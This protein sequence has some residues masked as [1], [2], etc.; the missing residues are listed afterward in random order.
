MESYNLSHTTLC[1]LALGR[2][3]HLLTLPIQ[4]GDK[5]SID[6]SEILFRLGQLRQ[7]L[8]AQVQVDILGFF[9]PY[10]YFI[11]GWLE[12]VE[13]ND[14][15][16]LDV[17]ATNTVSTGGNYFC[18]GLPEG[19]LPPNWR[20]NMYYSIYN[21]YFRHPTAQAELS[22]NTHHFSISEAQEFGYPGN[23]I[24][25]MHT[26]LIWNTLP[27]STYRFD[28]VNNDV[29][30]RD[31]EATQADVEVELDRLYKNRRYRDLMKMVY[32]G[33]AVEDADKRP[34][35]LFHHVDY[36]DSHDVDGTTEANLGQWTGK[37]MGKAG[38]RMPPR[39]FGEHGLLWVVALPR[40]PARFETQQNPY[41]EWSR[42]LRTAQ[43]FERILAD[44]RVIPAT[45]IEGVK[46][47]ELFGSTA[48]TQIAGH[49][50]AGQIYR[51][52]P[53]L[54][55]GRYYDT[56][57]GFGVLPDPDNTGYVNLLGCPREE[58]RKL[59]HARH[60]G[61]V[62]VQANFGIM[63]WSHLPPAS[64]SVYVGAQ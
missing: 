15:T 1:G 20:R 44:P 41:A 27:D 6:G 56:Q 22:F 53:G 32:G 8:Q 45:P 4:A 42:N 57:A 36:I 5:V 29:D 13:D 59:F 48:S 62:Q 17:T 34:H 64:T 47:N 21:H 52:H 40:I 3:G 9:C 49:L 38:F 50:P 19:T 31:L 46:F 43:N 12:A 58:W 60:F 61:D 55:T 14:Y 16:K 7:S 2:I 54:T 51:E 10:R 33:H 23:N 28:V 30:V 26:A 11:P 25:D 35:F 63:R 24:K 37:G 18:L 39:F